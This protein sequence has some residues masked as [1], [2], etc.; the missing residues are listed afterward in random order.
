MPLYEAPPGTRLHLH[1][2]AEYF[3][4]AVLEQVCLIEAGDA[5]NPC[6]AGLSELGIDVGRSDREHRSRTWRADGD[7]DALHA[8]SVRVGPAER[9]VIRRHWLD[10][11][12]A[13]A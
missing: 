2:F 8:G 13:P 10:D 3:W 9:G 1:L 4:H 12:T 7:V 5:L 11:D 6:L